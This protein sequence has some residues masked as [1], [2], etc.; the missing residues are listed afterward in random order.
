MTELELESIDGNEVVNERESAFSGETV[1]TV[2]DKDGYHK[3]VNK[4]GDELTVWPLQSPENAG[5]DDFVQCDP[6]GEEIIT[7]EAQERMVDH[8]SEI[9]GITPDGVLYAALRYD[10]IVF[11]HY[12][13]DYENYHSSPFKKAFHRLTSPKDTIV[14]IEANRYWLHGDVEVGNTYGKIERVELNGVPSRE[15]YDHQRKCKELLKKGHIQFPAPVILTDA[16]IQTHEKYTAALQDM[17]VAE[18]QP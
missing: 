13:D 6:D 16:T 10:S 9:V 5:Q 2:K 1:Y 8:A 11:P 15:K 12:N 4:E 18:Y 7:Q 14:S 3:D 17:L